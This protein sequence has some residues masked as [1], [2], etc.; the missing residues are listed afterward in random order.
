L[1]LPPW[2]LPD[3]PTALGR[4]VS[5]DDSLAWVDWQGEYATRFAFHNGR[6][7][8]VLGGF[9]LR[10]R[11]CR[12]RAAHGGELQ[13]SRGAIGR[14]DSAWRAPALGRLLPGSLFNIEEQKWRSRAD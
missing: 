10:S 12:G 9:R 4:F 2:Q 7:C 5:P 14:D 11:D 8:E 13:P 3:A 1:T 6:E